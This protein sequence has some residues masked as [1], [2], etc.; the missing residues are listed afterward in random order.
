MTR[1]HDFTLAF[2]DDMKRRLFIARFGGEH[3]QAMKEELDL[4]VSDAITKHDASKEVIH[5]KAIRKKGTDKWYIY[6]DEWISEKGHSF[7]KHSIID[8][9]TYEFEDKPQDAELVDIDI[10]VKGGEE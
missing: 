10:I 8:A 6:L 5:A 1:K 7:L 2:E 3:Q 4:I 9:D